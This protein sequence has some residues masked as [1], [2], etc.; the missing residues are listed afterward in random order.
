MSKASVLVVDDEPGVR[1]ML[2]DALHLQGYQ[3]KAVA[4]GFEALKELRSSHFDLVVSDIN[5][6][7]IDGYEMLERMRTVGDATPVILLT[8]RGEK[9]DLARGFRTGADDYVTKPFGLEELSLRIEAV[10]RR[11]MGNGVAGEVLECGPLQL[12]QDAHT[13]TVDGNAVELSQTEFRL[14]VELLERK[15]K[16]ATKSALLDS[17][18]GIN[19]DT[20]VSVLDTYISYLRK[21]LHTDSWQGIKTVRGVGFQITSKP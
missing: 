5:M 7:K 21:K 2:T 18:W 11:T 4:D 13:V 19:W 16:V 3:V 6:P 15:E 1:D 17:V 14:L 20:N 8:A 12:N 9:A 10:L